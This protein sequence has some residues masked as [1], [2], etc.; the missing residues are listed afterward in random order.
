VLDVIDERLFDLALAGVRIFSLLDPSFRHGTTCYCKG[1]GQTV[2]L[3][4]F[5]ECVYE[6][7][8]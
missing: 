2:R 7:L 6:V 5:H 3:R 4:Q 8:Y 1:S